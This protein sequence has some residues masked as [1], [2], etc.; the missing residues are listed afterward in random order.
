MVG[1]GG[2]RD[3]LPYLSSLETKK[4]LKVLVLMPAHQGGWDYCSGRKRHKE[5]RLP[6]RGC[7]GMGFCASA[8]GQMLRVGQRNCGYER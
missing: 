7:V 3:A 8:E 5:L 1:E 2:G 6:G 4:C